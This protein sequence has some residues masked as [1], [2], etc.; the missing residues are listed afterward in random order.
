MPRNAMAHKT[1]TSWYF[2]ISGYFVILQVSHET[3]WYFKSPMRLRDTFVTFLIYKEAMF[4]LFSHSLS[5]H[6]LCQW[7]FHRHTVIS[8]DITLLFLV[9]LVA[10]CPLH[11]LL[12]LVRLLALAVAGH[13]TT[14]EF[15]EH[16]CDIDDFDHRFVQH[17]EK[18]WR[19][20]GADWLVGVERQ[21]A[22]QVFVFTL[23]LSLT[24][25]HMIW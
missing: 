11:Y 23:S 9:T 2:G 17:W 12:S 18:G 21:L 7:A 20:E 1:S 6:C 10:P 16:R 5:S 15:F 24:Q 22:P 13:G 25:S 3:S 4:C 8:R 14:G 19:D